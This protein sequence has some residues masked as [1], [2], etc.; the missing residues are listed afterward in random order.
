M[1]TGVLSILFPHEVLLCGMRHE[2]DEP[3]QFESFIS[4][5]YV[6]EQHIKLATKAAE[7]LISRSITAWESH[8][9]PIIIAEGRSAGDYGNHHVPFV[10]AP[11]A[12]QQIELKNIAAHGLASKTGEVLSF[13]SFSRIPGELNAKHAYLLELLVPHMHAVLLR[14]SGIN[15]AR[16]DIKVKS[17]IKAVRPISAREKEVLQWLHSG[18]TNAEIGAI[19]GI[20]P[21]TVKNQVH[22]ILRKLGVEN[23]SN[24]ASKAK[25][26]GLF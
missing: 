18:K 8:H 26:R 2:N 14:I 7:G 20:S 11:G 10:E 3:L 4:T 22:S 21:L 23:R 16:Y 17:T 5:R 9:R 6:T 15:N 13:F 19:L 1:V 25:A 24:A 12:L